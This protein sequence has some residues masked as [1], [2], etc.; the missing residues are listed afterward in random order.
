MKSKVLELGH[1]KKEYFISHNI[2]VQQ[3]ADSIIN[4][5]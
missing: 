1:F 5:N 2:P 3:R 4:F